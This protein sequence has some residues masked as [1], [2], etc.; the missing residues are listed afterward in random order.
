M[1]D[2]S[3]IPASD[4]GLRVRA[5]LV[6]LLLA[7]SLSPAC[8]ERTPKTLELTGTV[9]DDVVEVAAP[10]LPVP[11]PD[12]EAGFASVEETPAIGGAE[13]PVGVD[14]GAAAQQWNRVATV[15][16]R[17]GDAV[18]AGQ[19][20]MI[21]DDAV[22]AA[23]AEQAR[24]AA[25]VSRADLA[26]VG[27]RSQEA[28]EGVSDIEDE[29]SGISS[30]TAELQIQRIDLQLQL[31]QARFLVGTP[32]P[33]GTPDPADKVAELEAAIAEIDTAI[34][35][36]DSARQELDEASADVQSAVTALDSL[37]RAMEAIANALD[38]V[39]QIAEA[40]RARSVITAPVAGVV[41]SSVATGT[42]VTAGTPLV[43]IRPSR[44]TVV[45]T[46]VTA[47]ERELITRGSSARVKADSMPDNVLAGA[48]VEIGNEY[49]YVPTS[50]ATKVIHLARG[51]E[52]SIV[53]YGSRVPPPGTPVDVSIDTL[54]TTGP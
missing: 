32:V 8:A 29:R 19:T 17:P 25:S 15:G 5:T 34:Q 46:Y 40:Q 2:T 30:R 27:Q 26:A 36:L 14:G 33:T 18:T 51:L 42:V 21:L 23:D 12:I 28:S 16:V 1:S 47:K 6:V 10:Q 43:T 9:A 38:V 37:T 3:R 11:T 45:K 13:T 39:A 54:A 7:S 49:D 44:A 41:T 4:K 24:A 50:F 48:V 52:V 20:L 22:L 31:D 35:E 53:I